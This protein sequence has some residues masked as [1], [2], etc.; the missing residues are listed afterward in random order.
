MTSSELVKLTP[1]LVPPADTNMASGPNELTIFHPD[2]HRLIDGPNNTC[3]KS[4]W[5]DVVHPDQSLVSARDKAMHDDRRRLWFQ[6][7]GASCELG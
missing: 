6:G 2:I 3:T 4:A 5:Y 7:L 1:T